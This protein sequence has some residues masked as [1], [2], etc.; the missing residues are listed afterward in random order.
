MAGR[1]PWGVLAAAATGLLI[2]P[3]SWSHHWVWCVPV[4]AVLAA[5]GRWRAAG[6]VAVAFTAR[7][8][9]LVPHEGALDL[10][11][12]WWQQPLA[13]PYPLLGL[14]LLVYA[15]T[16]PGAGPGPSL[17]P[18]LPAVGRAARPPGFPRP[19]AGRNPAQGADEAAG[20]DGIT[21]TGRAGN[22]G[23]AGRGG[24]WRARLAWRARRAWRA[25][26]A[27]GGT[28]RPA[29][30]RNSPGSKGVGSEDSPIPPGRGRL[31]A[32]SAVASRG[33]RP[34]QT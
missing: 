14:A 1:E 33:P 2:S 28:E 12:P 34:E 23:K 24:A 9:W 18:S 22:A 16:G 4:L 29:G 19:W 21:R 13:S 11:L 10:R 8:L 17:A 6:A 32:P 7:T 20:R 27:A 5:E 30:C 15:A 25:N 26:R 3:I 31:H